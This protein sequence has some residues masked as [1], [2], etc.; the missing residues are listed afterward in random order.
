MARFG[1]YPGVVTPVDSLRKGKLGELFVL[2]RE[3]IG[4]EGGKVTGGHCSLGGP[5]TLFL[6]VS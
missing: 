1:S 6:A 2:A 3:D 5:A 4:R